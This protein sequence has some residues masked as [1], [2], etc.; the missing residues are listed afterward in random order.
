[1]WE[2]G[3]PLTGLSQLMQEGGSL[4]TGFYVTYDH[5]TIIFHLKSLNI[6][7]AATYADGN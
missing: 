7:M 3:A 6:T 2:G 4:L 5:G 1:M